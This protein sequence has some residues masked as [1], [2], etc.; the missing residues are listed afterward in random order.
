MHS[1]INADGDKD[2]FKKKVKLRR[3]QRQAPKAENNI[4]LIYGGKKGE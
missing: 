3:L 2:C 4:L 1:A